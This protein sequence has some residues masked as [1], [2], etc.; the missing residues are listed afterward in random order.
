VGP[1]R[2]DGTIENHNKETAFL[3]RFLQRMVECIDKNANFLV[4]H[5]ITLPSH[6]LKY[7]N[8]RCLM[9]VVR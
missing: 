3:K 2:H 4:D 9:P 7:W 6:I 5:I 8:D 1:R